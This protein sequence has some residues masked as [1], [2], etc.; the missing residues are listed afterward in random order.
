MNKFLKFAAKWLPYAV[1]ISLSIFLWSSL[2]NCSRQAQQIYETIIF[3]I[4]SGIVTSALLLFFTVFWRRGSAWSLV[5]IIG[6]PSPRMRSAH[7][8]IQWSKS[9][10]SGPLIRI[11]QTRK[12]RAPH[13]GR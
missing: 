4:L 3:G 9:V 1:L 6:G 2:S 10:R 12:Q 11:E 13:P 7:Q 8:F 5:L